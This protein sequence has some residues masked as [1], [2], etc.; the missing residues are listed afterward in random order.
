MS[1]DGRQAITLKTNTVQESTLVAGPRAATWGD[2][3]SGDTLVVA[4]ERLCMQELRAAKGRHVISVQRA[5]EDPMTDT[6]IV[7]DYNYVR[8]SCARRRIRVMSWD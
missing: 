6:L 4:G 7:R 2:E 8:I 3:K 5:G 1:I